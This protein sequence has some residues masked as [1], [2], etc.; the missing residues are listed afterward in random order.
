MVFFFWS[1][2]KKETCAI[3]K[4]QNDGGVARIGDKKLKGIEGVI[5]CLL[6]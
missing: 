5:V 3:A 4:Y 6:V 2:G 1:T